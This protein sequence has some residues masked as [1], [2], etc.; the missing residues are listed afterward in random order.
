MVNERRNGMAVS[1]GRSGSLGSVFRVH[2]N[3]Q[4][5]LDRRMVH[6]ALSAR[7]QQ[8]V[9]HLPDYCLRHFA[10]LRRL[11]RCDERLHHESFVLK[12]PSLAQFVGFTLPAL[13][14]FQC[15]AA[16]SR[17]RA[18]VP[19]FTF[20]VAKDAYPDIEYFLGCA[21]KWTP[22]ILI[23]VLITPSQVD[24]ADALFVAG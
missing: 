3:R 19:L 2:P 13:A 10:L 22:L 9:Q 16:I 18:A 11:C 23:K 17:S 7:H 5:I 20:I 15:E 1:L 4:I 12:S 24:N 6:R 21:C 8:F 14:G